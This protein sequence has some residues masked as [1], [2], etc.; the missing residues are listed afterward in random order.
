MRVIVC[1]DDRNGMLFNRRRQSRDR[2][3]VEDILRELGEKRLLVNGFRRR[4][5]ITR[6]IGSA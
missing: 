2:R 6:A 5:S 1:L 4:C 3:V